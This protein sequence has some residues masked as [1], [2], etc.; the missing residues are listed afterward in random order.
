[1]SKRFCPTAR[2]NLSFLSSPD[3]GSLENLF[4]PCLL[5]PLINKGYIAALVS[6]SRSAAVNNLANFRSTLLLRPP[7]TRGS[8]A[9]EI[10]KGTAKVLH[11]IISISRRGSGGKWGE[12]GKLGIMTINCLPRPPLPKS[13]PLVARRGKRHRALGLP[14]PSQRN[15]P[16]FFFGGG[17]GCIPSFA[18]LLPF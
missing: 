4:V 18:L 14:P 8:Q 13:P 17:G 6:L 11:H 10:R 9:V 15:R 12:V 1:M 5:A 3:P 16:L 7:I 2:W